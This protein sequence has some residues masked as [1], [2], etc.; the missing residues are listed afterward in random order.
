MKKRW[1]SLVL[2]KPWLANVLS[3]DYYDVGVSFLEGDASLLLSHL[4]GPQKKIAWVHIDL[5]RHHTLPREIEKAVYERMDEVVCVSEGVKQ[6]VLNLHP[7]LE[8]NISVIYNPVDTTLIAAKGRRVSRIGQIR[9]IEC[10]GYWQIAGTRRRH[11]IPCWLPI[12]RILRQDGLSSH[13]SW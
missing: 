1:Y 3:P 10:T 5:E 6:S 2:A 9:G 12:I 11:S 4:N 7:V 13:H 8:S